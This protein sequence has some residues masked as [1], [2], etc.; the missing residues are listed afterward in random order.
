MFNV[1]LQYTVYTSPFILGEPEVLAYFLNLFSLEN[2]QKLLTHPI[3]LFLLNSGTA[4]NL[5]NAEQ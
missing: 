5:E 4:I 1:A 2:R 3:I